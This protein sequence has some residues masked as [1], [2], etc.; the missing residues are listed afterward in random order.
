MDS[1]KQIWIPPRS[2]INKQTRFQILHEQHW[3]CNICN[4]KLTYNK[5]SKWN[6]EKCHIDHIHPYSHATTYTNGHQNINE[7]QNLQALCE[8]CNCKKS[9][10]RDAV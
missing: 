2:F 8:S 4:T 7:R 6:G 9:N 10:K 1:V 3:N 5:H